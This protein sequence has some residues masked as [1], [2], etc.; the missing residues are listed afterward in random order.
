MNAFTEVH[1]IRVASN[2]AYEAPDAITIEEPMEIRLSFDTGKGR[3][4][5]TVSVTMR[6]PGN[7]HELAAGFLYSEGVIATADAI[8]DISHT[9]HESG[10]VVVVRLRDGVAPNIGSLERNFYTTSACGVCGKT[11]IDAV[12]N[13]C[14]VLDTKDTLCVPAAILYPLPELLRETQSIFKQT[15]GLHGCALFT[16][17]GELILS[18]EDAGR[19]NAMDKLTG[20]ML[21]EG[22]LPLQQHILM[23][24]GRASFELIQKAAMAGIKI[25]AAVGAPSSLA[26]SMADEWGMTLIGFLREHKFNIYTG[27][28]RIGLSA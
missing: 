25:V 11:S 3:T 26:V 18:R 23:L 21:L 13:A 9:K 2:T 8:E 6:T 28:Q 24:S 14:P 12:M 10:N 16:A 5:K 7:D 15:G 4:T 27:A 19:H 20:A 22:K 1:I 17:E